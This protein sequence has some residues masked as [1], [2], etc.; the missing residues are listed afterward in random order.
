MLLKVGERKEMPK[1]FY[2]EQDTKDVKLG[3]RVIQTMA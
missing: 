2:R 1:K 3:D